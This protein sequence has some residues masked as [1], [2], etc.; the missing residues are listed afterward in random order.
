[1]AFHI[2]QLTH[3]MSLEADTPTR[4]AKGEAVHDWRELQTVWAKIA[5]SSAFERSVAAQNSQKIT[6]TITVRYHAELGASDVE[7]SPKHR[8]IYD[9]R[10][11]EIQG[12][13]DPDESRRFLELTCEE[14]RN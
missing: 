10:T 6:H 13:I 9:S 11:F 3:Q 4:N 7:F 2:G 8:L 12:I 1:M 5:P 14:T